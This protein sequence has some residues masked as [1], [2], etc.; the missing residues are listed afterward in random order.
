MES[1]HLL[2]FFLLGSIPGGKCCLKNRREINKSQAHE[3]AAVEKLNSRNTTEEIQGDQEDQMR[4]LLR[5]EGKEWLLYLTKA[6]EILAETYSETYYLPDGSM[7]TKTRHQLDH[8]CYTGFVEGVEESSVSLCTCQGLSGYILMGDQEYIIDPVNNGT[9]MHKVSRTPHIRTKR[10]L[11]HSYSQPLTHTNLSIELYLVADREEFLQNGEDLRKTQER[12]ITLAHYVNQI[13]Q[14]QLDIQIFLVGIEVWT[15]KNKIG[16]SE[17]TAEALENF[18]QW[19][20]KELVPRK[21]HDNA[22]LISGVPFQR[23]LGQAY[24]SEMCSKERSGGVV[25]DD[26]DYIRELAK[27]V[28]HEMGHNLGMHH[29]RPACHCPVTSGECLLATTIESTMNPIFSDCSK[30]FLN[31]FLRRFNVSC[32]KDRPATSMNI[33]VALI[34]DN[35]SMNLK[36][37][38]IASASLVLFIFAAVDI[39][40]FLK[41]RRKEN[42]TSSI[43]HVSNH[44]LPQ[45]VV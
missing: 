10:H 7:V 32:L 25:K 8:C 22:Q 36:I 29:D 42:C 38:I 4:Y 28:A 19:R 26:Q 13:Y 45:S 34:K 35:S 44:L 2:V 33:T 20:T 9:G 37:G 23:S 16:S 1:K 3:L 43:Q 41:H 40:L 21:H 6:R 14:K 31:S 39:L 5:I 15:D 12:L 18:M 24:L 27:Y 30:K 11:S 17:D